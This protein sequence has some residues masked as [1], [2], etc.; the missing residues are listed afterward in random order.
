VATSNVYVKRTD[1]VRRGILN[2]E[3]DGLF[4]FLELEALV[5]SSRIGAEIF[6]PGMGPA[7]VGAVGVE[8]FDVSQAALSASS[9]TPH[10]L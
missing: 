10:A 5:G 2:H 4:A 6:T 9:A 1:A 3:P 8:L 7:T